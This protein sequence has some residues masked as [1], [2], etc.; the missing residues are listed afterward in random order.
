MKSTLIINSLISI[1][2]SLELNHARRDWIDDLFPL[3]APTSTPPQTTNGDDDFWQSFN[4]AATRASSRTTNTPASSSTPDLFDQLFGTPTTTRSSTTSSSSTADLFDQLFGTPS[5]TSSRSSRSS[6]RTRPT[7]SQDAPDLI[8]YGSSLETTEADSDSSETVSNTAEPF[9]TEGVSD[10][11]LGYLTSSTSRGR[12]STELSTT[13]SSSTEESSTEVSSTEVSSTEVSSTESSESS[14]ER[15]SSEYS[16]EITSSEIESS[17]SLDLS[18][19]GG[20]FGSGFPSALLAYGETRSASPLTDDA[21]TSPTAAPTRPVETR[22]SLS[23]QGPTFPSDDDG[24][25]DD[26]ASRL[27]MSTLGSLAIVLIA[28][29]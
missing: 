9:S 6:S 2:W 5:T 1:A 4:Q 3:S 23:I 22:T 13:E 10:F 15:S 14:S 29:V 27:A 8:G 26:A 28:L 12:R 20:L 16:S 7:T 21:T 24:T 11:L 18:D 17:E 25:S 19:V